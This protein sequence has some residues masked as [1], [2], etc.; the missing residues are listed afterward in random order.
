MDFKYFHP[1]T[2]PLMVGVKDDVMMMLD[3]AHD[4][5]AK[6]PYVITCGLRTPDQNCKLKGAVPDSAHET[7]LAV[8]LACQDDH[9]L[10]CM[11]DG[12]IHAGFNRIGIYLARDPKDPTKFVPRHIH[13]DAD[14]SKPPEVTWH[15]VE[16]N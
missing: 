5:H 11:L 14:T 2:D 12:L 6:I 9:S 3:S 13:V 16:Q 15:Y 8:D 1:N 4:V 7:G 10:F